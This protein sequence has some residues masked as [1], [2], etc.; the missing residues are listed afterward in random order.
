MLAAGLPSQ[1]VDELKSEPE[2]TVSMDDLTQRFVE[3]LSWAATLH[4]SQRRKANA[5]PYVAH[6]LAVAA[7][8]LEHGGDEDEAIAALLHDAIEDQGGHP[9]RLQ[10]DE[11]FGPRV[12]AIVEGATET[13]L[14][15]KPPWRQRKELHLARLLQADRSVQLIVAAD[16]LHNVGSLIAD[17]GRL[18][19][20]LWAHFRGGKAGTLWYLRAAA[21]ALPL[22]PAELVAQLNARITELERL[23]A[24]STD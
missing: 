8:V 24:E 16:K 14:Q 23:A 13:D 5:T 9:T 18:G 15:P 10:I 4:Q 17:Y 19:A 7:L 11:R 6:L 12:A 3:A 1:T 22:A 20:G 21:A 2:S